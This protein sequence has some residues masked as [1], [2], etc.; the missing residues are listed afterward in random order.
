MFMSNAMCDAFG[1][2]SPCAPACKQT[3][4]I[5]RRLGFCVAHTFCQSHGTS[6]P[7]AFDQYWIRES[8]RVFHF[9]VGGF[10]KSQVPAC[11]KKGFLS[12]LFLESLKR[13]VHALTVDP[14]SRRMLKLC[15]RPDRARVALLVGENGLLEVAEEVRAGTAPAMDLCA[16]LLAQDYSS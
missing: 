12:R 5:F 9:V 2:V 16:H 6:H 15:V 14:S 4:V 13:P 3:S 1:R 10:Q 7:V 11:P 8:E